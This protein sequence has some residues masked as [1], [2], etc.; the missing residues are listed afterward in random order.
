MTA[1]ELIRVVNAI[2]TVARHETKVVTGLMW[3]VGGRIWGGVGRER[4]R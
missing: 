2:G 1:N 4:K 3:S